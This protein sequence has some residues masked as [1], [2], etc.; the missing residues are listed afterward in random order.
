MRARIRAPTAMQARQPHGNEDYP[1]EQDAPATRPIRREAGYEHD[2]YYHGRASAGRRRNIYED[3]PPSRRR[4]GIMAIAGVFALA[5]IGTAGAFG[6]RAMFGS[7]GSTRPPPVIKAEPA[8]S[9][10]VPATTG[11]D[12]QSNKLITDRDRTSA[13]RARNWCRARSSRSTSRQWPRCRNQRRR[14]RSVAAWSRP[15]RRKSAPLPFVRISHG[16]RRRAVIAARSSR[17][18]APR[19]VP[20][21][22]PQA[23]APHRRHRRARL[24]R[25]RDGATPSRISH[26]LARACAAARA[27]RPHRPP[28]AMR[29]CR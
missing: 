20:A 9:K 18:A 5:V 26:R 15:S 25:H 22:P 1:A 2:G 12:A 13:A 4:L 11:K 8:P 23:P 21:P 29:R 24:S 6:Y 7:S 16:R 17:R 19:A 28:T 3:V 14:R 10:I 27:H